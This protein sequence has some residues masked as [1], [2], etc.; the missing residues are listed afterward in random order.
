MTIWLPRG[1]ALDTSDETVL[2]VTPPDP[3]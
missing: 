3:V 1:P 2:E